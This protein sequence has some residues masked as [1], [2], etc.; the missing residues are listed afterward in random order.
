MK[1]QEIAERIIELKKKDLALRNQLIE[2]KQLG[3]GYNEAMAQLHNQN[4]EALDA[5]IDQIGYPTVDNVG[6]AASAAAWLVIQHSIGQP[7]FMKKCAEL[8]QQEGLDSQVSQRELAYLSDRIAVFEGKRQR[9]GTQFDWDEN[10]V[11]SPH[12][13]DDVSQVNQRR[14]A[15]G[16]NSL[17][18]QLIII[19]EQ[20]QQEHQLPPKDFAKRKK[21]ILEWKK[22]VGWIK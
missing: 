8:L 3:D 18:E 7:S 5:I 9:Y 22:A 14:K 17:E 2:A 19:R 10:G 16:L 6:K 13:F 20:A 12:P 15:I 21:A 1:Y 4:A 11:L